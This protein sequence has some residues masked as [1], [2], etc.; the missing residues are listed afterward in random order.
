MAME[1][2]EPLPLLPDELEEQDT[3]SWDDSYAI[4][5]ALHKQYPHLPLE[6]VSLGMVFRWTLE[7]PAFQDDPELANEAILSAIY[8]EWFEEANPL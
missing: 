7:L 2:T 5:L 1:I 6:E 3:L 4:A 8:Q